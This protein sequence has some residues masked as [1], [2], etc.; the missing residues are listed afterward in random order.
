MK[1]FTVLG[2]QARGV[3]RMGSV[4]RQT[5]GIAS[6]M[7]VI[8]QLLAIHLSEIDMDCKAVPNRGAISS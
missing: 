4:Q 1:T 2:Q 6:E 3:Y 8:T 5:S 7:S